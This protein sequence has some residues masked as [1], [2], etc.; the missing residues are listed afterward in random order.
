[1]PEI[2][3]EKIEEPVMEEAVPETAAPSEPVEQAPE[4]VTLDPTLEEEHIP[5]P[6]VLQ[7]QLTQVPEPA[8]KKRGRPP[9]A[10]AEA[11]PK[12]P[13]PAPKPKAT[14]AKK[15][16]PP[17]S[18]SSSEDMDETLRNV[19]NHVAKPD[20]ETAILQ[21]LVNRKQSEQARRRELWGRLAQM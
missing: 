6:P 5:E 14:R 21:F 3:L 8:P 15:P 18:D 17:E 12:P 19:Y 7:R 4:E 2:V 13:K 9:K 1:M 11:P 16:A 20:M 10:K